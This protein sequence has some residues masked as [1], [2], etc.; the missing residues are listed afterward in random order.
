MLIA[1][2]A[3]NPACP[4]AVL[5]FQ[6]GTFTENPDG[7]LS[8]TPFAVDGRQLTS[9][10]CKFSNSI[11]ARYNQTENYEVIQVV[12]DSLGKAN[13]TRNTKYIMMLTMAFSAS[14]SSDLTDPQ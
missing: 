4:S 14:T 10:P 13:G 5:Q 6:H 1:S 2:V 12:T 8:L 9:N 7:S 11:Y 3:T